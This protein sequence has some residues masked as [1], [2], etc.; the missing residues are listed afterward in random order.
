M[1]NG[2]NIPKKRIELL[3]PQMVEGWDQIDR[4]FEII[5]GIH[6]MP[7]D[8]AC[9]VKAE[10]VAAYLSFCD[11]QRLTRCYSYL[12]F[13]GDGTAANRLKVG[14][15]KSPEFRLKAVKPGSKPMWSFACAFSDMKAAY[16][17]EQAILDHFKDL[18]AHGEWLVIEPVDYEAAKMTVVAARSVAERTTNSVAAYFEIE[19]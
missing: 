19:Q 14:I 2:D 8:Y 13:F 15:S 18:R 7:I 5:H 17:V 16:R 1:H 11:P 3:T 12:A 4:A 10:M 9:T 6:L